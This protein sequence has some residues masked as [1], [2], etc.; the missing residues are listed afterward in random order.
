LANNNHGDQEA[1]IVNIVILQQ[2]PIE[3]T[4]TVGRERLINSR[5]VSPQRNNKQ[6]YVHGDLI[7]IENVRNRA[8]IWVNAKVNTVPDEVFFLFG[9][10][11]KSVGRS[12]LEIEIRQV[13]VEFAERRALCR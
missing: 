1:T 3:L 5:N 9:Y 13:T 11:V 6:R 8:E 12:R 10:L 2:L 7:G 4:L